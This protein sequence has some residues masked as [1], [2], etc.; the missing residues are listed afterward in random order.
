MNETQKAADEAEERTR[1]KERSW[2]I[3]SDAL[4]RFAARAP[5]K[6]DDGVKEHGPYIVTCNALDHMEDEIIDMWFYLQT[7]REQI[8]GQES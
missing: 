8:S 3:K 7:L 6:F 2:K 4:R 1:V 5:K